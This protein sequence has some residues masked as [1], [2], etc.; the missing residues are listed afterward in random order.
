MGAGVFCPSLRP[1]CLARLPR[2]AP[3]A[4]SRAPA[5][6]ST[7]Q[8]HPGRRDHTNVQVVVLCAHNGTQHQPKHKNTPHATEKPISGSFQR[9][10]ARIDP[11]Y[12][13]STI[14]H[15]RT[16]PHKPH[17]PSIAQPCIMSVNLCADCRTLL[18][19]CTA[20]TQRESM[21]TRAGTRARE[22]RE[23]AQRVRQR[24]KGGL[25]QRI[26]RQLLFGHARPALQTC[27]QHICTKPGER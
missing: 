8:W 14:A 18:H 22:Q 17:L 2:D 24:A 23:Q 27:T 16:A 5:R 6:N 26:A 12:D 9:A 11:S 3:A 19:A 7:H 13:G 15:A 10:R 4:F 1:R 20:A 21:A 25:W